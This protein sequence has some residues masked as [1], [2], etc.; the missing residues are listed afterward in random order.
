V[1]EELSDELQFHVDRLT[2]QYAARGMN[3]KDARSKALRDVGNVDGWKEAC[4]DQR[5]L[6]LLDSL[7]RDTQ[8]ALRLA[9]KHRV[10]SSVIVLSLSLGVAGTSAIFSLVYALLIDPF[11]YRDATGISLLTFSAPGIR[12]STLLF[13]TVDYTRIAEAGTVLDAFAFKRVS[14]TVTRGPAESV[15]EVGFS[16]GAFSFL[17][18]PMLQGRTFGFSDSRLRDEPVDVAVLSYSFWQRRYGGSDAI[19]QTLE[20]DH[21]PFTIVGIA[22]PRFNWAGGDIYVPLRPRPGGGPEVNIALRARDKRNLGAVSSEIDVITHRLAIASPGL[23][24]RGIFRIKAVRMTDQMLGNIRQTLIV[25]SAA[26]A[27]L[28]LVACANVSMLLFA[29]AG[30]RR[31]EIAMRIA[32]GAGTGRILRQLLVEAVTLSLAGGALGLLM[33]SSAL[34]TLLVL[35]PANALPPELT[36]HMN[37]EVILATFATCV[38]TGI[39]FGLLPALEAGRI[40][41]N[42]SLQNGG[43]GLAGRVGGGRS[44]GM[45]I[46]SEVS[47]TILLMAG[48]AVT[49]R[50]LV[51]LHQIRLGYDPSN[52]IKVAVSLPEGEYRTWAGREAV[53]DRLLSG[54]ASI[55]GVR[56]A[57]ATGDAVPPRIGFPATF[58]G[59]GQHPSLGQNL[60][61]AL[62]GGDYFAALRIPLLRGRLLT[63][64][65]TRVARPLAVIN[66]EMMRRYWTD[67]R[68]PVG[69]RIHIPGLRFT[70]NI[71]MTPPAADQW[72]EVIGVV[73]TALNEGLREPPSPAVY[74]PYKFALTA[75]CDFLLK[76]ESD[77]H[78]M[79]RAVRDRVQEIEPTVAGVE[80]R[81]LDEELSDFDRALPRFLAALFTL[82]GSVA[83]TLAATGLYSVVSYGV[84]RRTREMAV[85]I[86]L[87]ATK[88]DVLTLVTSSTLRFVAMGVGVGLLASIMGLR[89]I[90]TFL[91]DWA[92]TDPFPLVTVIAVFIPVATVA[93][94]IPAQRAARISP[95]AALR[96]E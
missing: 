39:L 31:R 57:A 9:A 10:F 54:L 81:T 76:T 24:P 2:E 35:M 19:G 66:D 46:A 40:D 72:F 1:E 20:L 44:R 18:L 12:G 65:E 15:A 48:T 88:A 90:G 84:E 92:V 67:G 45:L 42:R 38:L 58:D 85:R 70:N 33:A 43:F 47:L 4:R 63:N 3:S 83:L 55:P 71:V 74:L 91:P 29:R 49:V 34:R 22:P 96:H 37:G 11:P 8:Y 32:L 77:P 56:L 69:K 52:V 5:G 7:L 59:E 25:L 64:A 78:G 68:D 75:H 14:S 93:S 61:V 51:A 17:G 41:V 21:E 23:Y 62:V 6:N 95:I 80:P 13:P 94:L 82:F 30:T 28:L 87:G 50:T 27:L 53:F 36:V 16:P 73:G 86:A 89:L 60:Q 26:S 79:I